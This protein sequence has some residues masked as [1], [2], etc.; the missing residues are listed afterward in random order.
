MEVVKIKTIV[1][2]IFLCS[3]LAGFFSSCF[4]D[5]L[6]TDQES[7]TEEHYLLDKDEDEEY[8]LFESEGKS[9]TRPKLQQ[10][11]KEKRSRC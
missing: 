3:L 11:Q 10:L 9:E 1:L 7:D 2:M 8:S 5:H 4:P 6:E